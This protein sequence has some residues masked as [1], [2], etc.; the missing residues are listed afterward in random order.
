MKEKIPILFIALEFPPLNTTGNYR[1]LKFVKYLPEF[2]FDPIVITLDENSGTKIFGNRIDY[3]LLKE[4]PSQTKVYR[5]PSNNI[6]DVIQKNKLLNHLRIFINTDDKIAKK[7]MVN[8]KKDMASIIETHNPKL[9]YIS[10][11]PFS[12]YRLVEYFKRE[13]NLPIVV[14]MRDAWSQWVI[15]SYQTKLHY[16]RVLA[17]ERKMFKNADQVITVTQQLSNVFQQTHPEINANKFSVITNGFDNEIPTNEIITPT[18]ESKKIRIGYIGS[19]YFNPDTQ[20]KKS[21]SSYI[22][23]PDKWFTYNPKLE[24]WSYRSPI[25]FL[26]SLKAL[27]SEKPDFK[28]R[29]SFEHIGN[30]PNWLIQYIKE[31]GL[32]NN[33]ISH[34]FLTHNE[35][36]NKQKEFDFLLATSE[37]KIDGEHYSLPSKI[38]DY[39][40]ANKC[41]LAFVTP[42]SQKDFLSNLGTAIL[43]DPDKIDEN[44]ELLNDILSKSKKLNVNS[45]FLSGYSRKKLTCDLSRVFET[46]N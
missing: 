36:L 29:V 13:F 5:I 39:V 14:D 11:P 15:S 12:G 26:Q 10:I 43:F 25:Y 45:K 9:V 27:I 6:S 28:E 40:Q 30:T 44:V 1:S 8:L 41:I 23:R 4:L 2:G 7:W 32:E 34:G 18:I 3:N 24:D 20:S 22:K 19:F 42:G 38:F 16:L 17:K 46:L 21:L 33:F 37:K 35:V 31:L